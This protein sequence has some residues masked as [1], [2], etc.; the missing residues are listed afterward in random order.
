L[1][2]AKVLHTPVFATAPYLPDAAGELRVV[3]PSRC[4]FAEPHEADCHPRIDYRRERK[5][6]PCFPLAVVR[7]RVHPVRRYTLYPPGFVPYGRRAVAPVSPSGPLLRDGDS[8]E[9]PWQ[10]TV[11]AAAIDAAAG[12]R[13][14]EQGASQEESCRRTQGRHLEMAERLAG[15]HPDLGTRAREQIATRLGVATLLLCDAVRDRHRCWSARGR[16]LVSVLAALPADG[17][18]MRRLLSAGMVAGLWARPARWDPVGGCWHRARPVV[19]PTSAASP[20]SPSSAARDPPTTS[21][22]DDCEA[23]SEPATRE[24]DTP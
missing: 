9:V 7:C 1:A 8:G 4:V 20:S 21:Q 23:V 6:G 2:Q 24:Q 22:G 11:F 5:T 13:W 14:P 15:V 12:E 3:V 17:S 19:T 18:V 16:M 10:R